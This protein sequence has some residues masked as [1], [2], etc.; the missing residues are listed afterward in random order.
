MPGV[1]NMSNAPRRR[2][3]VGAIGDAH[4][5]QL[6]RPRR[7][8][9]GDAGKAVT[10]LLDDLARIV[11]DPPAPFGVCRRRERHDL[12]IV[13]VPRSS[14]DNQLDQGPMASRS[15]PDSLDRT[16]PDLPCL[17]EHRENRA[18]G[19]LRHAEAPAEFRWRHLALLVSKATKDVAVELAPEVN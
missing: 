12:H 17:G 11:H 9:G 16:D 5:D 7:H 15:A 4:A 19:G 10:R 13:N 6:L 2:Q 18:H 14:V 3:E 1:P 8:G